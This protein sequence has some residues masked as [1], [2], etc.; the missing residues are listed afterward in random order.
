MH[1]RIDSFLIEFSYVDDARFIF[2]DELSIYYVD[3]VVSWKELYMLNMSVFKSRI[4]NLKI[5]WEIMS[6]F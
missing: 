1:N 4:Q 2:V 5:H 6:V 3:D